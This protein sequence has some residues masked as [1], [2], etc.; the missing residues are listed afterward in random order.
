MPTFETVRL[1]FYEAIDREY[2]RVDVVNSDNDIQ[3]LLDEETGELSLTNPFSIFVGGQVLDRG[4]TISRMI[5]FYYGRNPQTMQQDT[6]LQH[7][8]MFG[9]RS[10][11][12]LSVSR[13]YTTRR[14]HSNME[15]ITEIDLDL[16]NDIERGSLGSGV[17]FIAQKRQEE[18]YGQYGKIVPCSPDKIRVSDVI[19]L[20]PHT[21]IFPIGFTPINKQ[22]AKRIDIAISRKLQEKGIDEYSDGKLLSLDAAEEIIHLAYS[23]ITPDEASTRFITEEELIVTLRYMLA[24]GTELPVLVRTGRNLSKYRKVGNSVAYSNA[25]DTSSSPGSLFNTAV[26]FAN[27]T[28]VLMLIQQTGEADG[29]GGRPFWWTI[30]VASDQVNM[31]M[32]ASKLPSER[33]KKVDVTGDDDV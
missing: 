33:V 30:V 31:T 28:P 12:L 6:V 17:Y 15:K 8:R 5:G 26:K 23:A 29:W 32:Y 18:Q 16:R 2:Y 25:P 24:S 1:R 4:V 7:S 13:F 21:R 10:K 27:D 14:I 9:Y 22:E 20:K 11:E 19:F 3:D